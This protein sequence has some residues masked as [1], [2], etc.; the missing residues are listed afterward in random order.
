[1]EL[2]L[3]IIPHVS[4]ALLEAVSYVVCVMHS[5]HSANTLRAP[6]THTFSLRH[7]AHTAEKVSMRAPVRGVFLLDYPDST[8]PLRGF[9]LGGE[10]MLLLPLISRWLND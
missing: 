1:M 10:K 3:H 9:K 8:S 4:A 2:E 6:S 7:A 5:S